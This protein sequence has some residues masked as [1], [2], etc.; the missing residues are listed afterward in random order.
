[1]QEA[2]TSPPSTLLSLQTVLRAM[3]W[4]IRRALQTHLQLIL[5]NHSTS[6]ATAK[7]LLADKLLQLKTSTHLQLMQHIGVED[8]TRHAVA[9]T[10]F[11]ITTPTLQPIRNNSKAPR[12][13]DAP[14]M[15]PAAI[16]CCRLGL[17]VRGAD[18][19]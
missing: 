12:P 14:H 17:N 7:P 5:K 3:L 15:I 18:R 6:S 8:E 19:C 13:L 16:F 11:I 1:M 2:P 10:P 4:H 9:W